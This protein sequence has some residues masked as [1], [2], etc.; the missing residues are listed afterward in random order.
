MD[1]SQGDF[2]PF[3]SEVGA[4]YAL[5][6]TYEGHIKESGEKLGDP[7]VFNK[8]CAPQPGLSSVRTPKSDEMHES[9]RE[10]DSVVAEKMRRMFADLPPLLD[11]EVELGF[12]LLEEAS[13]NQLADKE[14]MPS[15]GYFLA[16]DL[17]VRSVQIA[18]QLAADRL[19]YWSRSKSFP[20]FLPTASEVWVPKTPSGH[21]FPDVRLELKVNGDVRQSENVSDI[22]YSP[23]R[24]IDIVAGQTSNGELSRGDI[25]LTGTPSGVALGMSKAKQMIAKLLPAPL[26]VRM[27]IGSNR[28]NPAFLQSGDVAEQS[29]E[30]L[31]SF[32]FVVDR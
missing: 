29:A 15:I 18:G 5:G 11:Y 24:M 27:G 12:I 21:E 23:R 32:R 30:W 26:L 6:L 9:L 14:W 10:L 4:I 8:T 1:V 2:Q 25:I 28:A 31:G 22:I 20:S 19:P 3:P 16:N 13:Q 7:I 17:T